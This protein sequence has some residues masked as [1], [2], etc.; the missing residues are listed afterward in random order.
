V[1]APVLTDGTV[2]LDGFRIADWRA[3][4]AGD[5][6]E[7]ARRFGRV[8]GDLTED[9]M[10][11]L[12]HHWQRGWRREGRVRAWAVRAG[13]ELVGGCELRLRDDAIAHL[14]YWTLAGHRGRGYATRAVRLVSGHAFAVM[15]IARIELFIE[16]DNAAS[17]AVAEGAGFTEEGVLRRRAVLAG[18]RHDVALWSRLNTESG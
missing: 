9:G 16:P 2:T 7:L 18:Q 10:R 15:G 17:L 11:R 8:P 3:H 13:D 14:E 1:R 12:I 6:D 4:L 5:D